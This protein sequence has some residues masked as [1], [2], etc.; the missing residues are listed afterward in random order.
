M[1][2]RF[3]SL[4]LAAAFMFACAV[5]ALAA[6][7]ID[8]GVIRKGEDILTLNEDDA[9]GISS[10]TIASFLVNEANYHQCSDSVVLTLCPIIY[11]YPDYAAGGFCVAAFYDI[12]TYPNGIDIDEMSIT[13]GGSKYTFTSLTAT[14]FGL[15]DSVSRSLRNWQ[16][17]SSMVVLDYDSAALLEAMRK[18]RSSEI[19]VSVKATNGESW[20]FTMG[21]TEIDS[22]IHAYNLFCNAGGLSEANIKFMTEA[23]ATKCKIEAAK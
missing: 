19:K 18:N 8:M 3:I 20:S 2:K 17:R 9:S 10:Y 14:E 7:G 15:G 21:Q 16:G 12:N 23:T 1:K 5:P 6:S 13:V 22:D 11:G 4:L